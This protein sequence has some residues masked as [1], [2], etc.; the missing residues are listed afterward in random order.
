MAR[1]SHGRST[2]IN[3]MPAQAHAIC[4]REKEGKYE[5][6]GGGEEGVEA[7]ERAAGGLTLCVGFRCIIACFVGLSSR[8]CHTHVVHNMLMGRTKFGIA[9]GISQ[10]LFDSWRHISAIFIQINKIA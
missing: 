6:E 10:G 4:E 7:E 8:A 9:C 5:D 3:G 2:Y 1:H